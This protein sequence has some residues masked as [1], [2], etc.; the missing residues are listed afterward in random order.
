MDSR[1]R[2]NDGFKKCVTLTALVFIAVALAG[3]GKK[4][5]PSPPPGVPSTYPQNY[6]Q[7]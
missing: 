6:P 1:L 3:C 2:G 4:G 5:P 7:Q